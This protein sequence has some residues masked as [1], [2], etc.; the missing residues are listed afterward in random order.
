MRARLAERLLARL[1]EEPSIRMPNNY[2]LP[3]VASLWNLQ[4]QGVRGH[5][6]AAS[7]AWSIFVAPW[8]S[9]REHRQFSGSPDA[10]AVLLGMERAKDESMSPDGQCVR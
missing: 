1:D 10:A 7:P 5:S 8:R 4:A 2:G 9:A 6:Y 3:S